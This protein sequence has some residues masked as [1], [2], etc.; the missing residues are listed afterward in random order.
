MLHVAQN[1]MECDSFGM[2]TVMDNHPDTY[3]QDLKFL[4]G[5]GCMHHYLFNWSLGQETITEHEIGTL[6][7]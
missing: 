4:P 6:L 1:E 7:V 2:Q 3:I 5:G